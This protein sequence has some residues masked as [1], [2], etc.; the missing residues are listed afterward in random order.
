MLIML[1]NDMS[2]CWQERAQGI[3]VRKE[4]EMLNELKYQPS[5]MLKTCMCSDI[6]TVNSFAAVDL[7]SYEPVLFH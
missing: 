3:K 2:C 4:M 5:L 6:N 7:S 1:P